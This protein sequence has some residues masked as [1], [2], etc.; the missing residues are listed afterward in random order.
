MSI[1]VVIP[2]KTASNFI[3]CLNAVRE[4]EPTAN[5]ILVDDGLPYRTT[6]M[7]NCYGGG[8]SVI[9][10]G[11]KPFVF[12]RNVNLGIMAA[13][14]DD[15]VILND[16]ALLQ[17]TGGF[18]AMQQ[19]A[20]EHPEYGIIGPLTNVSGNPEQ[21]SKTGI[22]LRE[23]VRCLPFLCV[24]VPRRTIELVG[25]LDERFTA[26]GFE[27]TDYCKRVRDAGLKVGIYEDCFVDHGSLTSTFRGEPRTP[28]D[29]AAG[30]EIYL[31]K[32][33]SLA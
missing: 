23:T 4:H 28:G 18:T 21:W 31:Q 14:D 8:P 27:D 24:L 20:S 12:A 3:P 16:D 6:E 15:L 17:T 9:V 29:I 22:R 33:G 25:L 5:V 32:W 10:H 1:S 30:R 7:W 11:E 19:A 13:G 26:Y 2:S